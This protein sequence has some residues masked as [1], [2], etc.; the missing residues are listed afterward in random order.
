MAVL[1]WVV[2][3]I[4]ATHVPLEDLLPVRRRECF[5]LVNGAGESWAAWIQMEMIAPLQLAYPVGSSKAAIRLTSRQKRPS[6]GAT[7]APSRRSGIFSSASSSAAILF[8]APNRSCSWPGCGN[9]CSE[10]SCWEKAPDG[11]SLPRLMWTPRP[12]HT[13]APVPQHPAPPLPAPAP[14]WPSEAPGVPPSPA[15]RRLPSGKWRP[16]WPARWSA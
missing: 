15:G 6:R 12:R 3:V 9:C 4:G 7:S 11:G 1:R 14:D 5:A 10:R 13:P 16:S 2:A 8:A